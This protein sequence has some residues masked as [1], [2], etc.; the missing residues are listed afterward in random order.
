LP[1]QPRETAARVVYL[2]EDLQAILDGKPNQKT[3]ALRPSREA[4]AMPDAS[5]ALVPARPPA[6]AE[7]SREVSLALALSTLRT[8]V[9]PDPPKPWLTLEEAAEYS[10]LPAAYLRRRALHGDVHGI[11]VGQGR[12]AFW[13]FNR[14]SLSNIT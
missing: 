12:H 10:G 1:K 4:K 6:E 14:E 8:V 5:L 9:P 11:N 7:M 3:I 13:R 2:V